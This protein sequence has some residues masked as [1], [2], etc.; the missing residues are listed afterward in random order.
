MLF[1]ALA[2][3][4]PLPDHQGRPIAPVM[5]YLGA[6]WLERPDR[7]EE[8]ATDK[9]LR[10][11]KVDV[12]DTVVD[13]GCG[14][15]FHARRLKG[16]VGP[17]GTVHCVDLQSEMLERAGAL[18]QAAGVELSLVQGAEDRIP[19]ADDSVDHL[20]MVDVYH[21]LADPSAMLTEMERVL[22][23]DGVVHF[24]EFRLEG[25]SATHIK[26]EHRMGLEQLRKELGAAGFDVVR[27]YDGLPSQHLV[28]ARPRPG[29]PPQGAAA[30]RLE[31]PAPGP[32]APGAPG[33]PG[34]FR[35]PG[36]GR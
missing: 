13:L 33:A 31:G 17:Q 3:A 30:P 16:L 12:G 25:F 27:V 29:P 11:L 15:G 6:D 24:V 35:A 5:S 34:G 28:T 19:V 2:C 23:D 14:T 36:V 22:D 1:L 8:E 4:Q 21:E 32:A 10:K 18:A 20:L 7:A 9:M 26:R